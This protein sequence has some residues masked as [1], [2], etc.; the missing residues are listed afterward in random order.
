M[1]ALKDEEEGGEKASA[2]INGLMGMV[3]DQ[4]KKAKEAKDWAT[5]DKIRDELNALGITIKDTKDGTE[6]SI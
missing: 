6:W 2:T 5:S 3:L 1:T 4:R